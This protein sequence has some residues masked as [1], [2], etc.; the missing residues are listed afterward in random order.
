MNRCMK[1]GICFASPGGPTWHGDL[2]L[3]PDG[4]QLRGVCITPS[5]VPP[6]VYIADIALTKR[7]TGEP[8]ADSEVGAVHILSCTPEFRRFVEQWSPMLLPY[9]PKK[10][11]T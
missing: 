2:F 6:D 10:D 7:S 11:L 3:E 9:L 1:T 4:L 5:S 8:Y